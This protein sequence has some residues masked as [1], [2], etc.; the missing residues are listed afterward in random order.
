MKIHSD[1]L[2]ADDV[3]A[4]AAKARRT[5]MQDIY[6][7]D[8]LTGGSRSRARRIE[9]HC[10]AENGRYATNSG[11]YGANGY[12]R[13]AS[14]SA[15]GYFIAELFVIDPEAIVGQY[16]GL[17]DYHATCNKYQPQGYKT[18]EARAF[19]AVCP[20]PT[21]NAGCDRCGMND[22]EPDSKL[23]SACAA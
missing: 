11:T 12:N 18:P 16:N 14:W 21:D 22:R 15:W 8:L 4:A 13:A 6:I 17:A 19:L 10:N 3:H 2:T 5:H 9:L 1:V 23:C 7:D 20:L